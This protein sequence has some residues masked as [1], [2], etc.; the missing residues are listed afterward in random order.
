[1][2]REHAIVAAFV[3]CL[4]LAIAAEE[5]HAGHEGEGEHAEEGSVRLTPQQLKMAELELQAVAGGTLAKMLEGPGEIVANDDKVAHLTPRVPGVV[6]QVLKTIGDHV[7][8][9]ELLAVLQSP[10]LGNAKIE[11]FT[12]KLNLDLAR[13]DLEREQ[14][15]HD[16]TQKLLDLLKS[17][18]EPADIDRRL[19][20]LAVGE[21][22]TRLLTTYSALRL[23]RSGRTRAERLLA[24][25]AISQADFEL[26]AKEFESAEAEYKGAYE[27]V[28]FRFKQRLVQAQRAGRVAETAFQNA[29]RRLHVLGIPEAQLA[30]LAKEKDSDVAR[31]E[32]R[33]PFTGVVT[34][35]HMTTGEHLDTAAAC[36]TITDLSS[37][38]CNVR[39]YPKDLPRVKVGQRVRIVAPGCETPLTGSVAVVHPLVSEKTRAAFVRVTLENKD[40]L[41]RPGL[42]VTG[43]IVEAEVRAAVAVPLAAIQTFEN[44]EIVFVAEE[45]EGEFEAKPVQRGYSDGV[46]VEIKSGLGAGQRV[47][48]RNSFILKAALGKGEG[49]HQH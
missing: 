3:G 9:G 19:Q 35:R 17:E 46:L 45:H 49:G 27:D 36:F 15:I 25:K 18:P 33:A 28:T 16:N 12:A 30:E 11:Y 31:Y 8:E 7:K 20:G 26:A 4:A 2:L 37:V 21:N 1:M 48:V 24:E 43:A 40:L 6:T 38:W 42:F 5:K 47:V 14:V 13:L 29:E 10:D 22:K 44:R 39:V 41:L 34:A 23:G 32:L